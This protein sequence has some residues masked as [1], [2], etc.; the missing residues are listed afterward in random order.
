MVN[1][2]VLTHEQIQGIGQQ[3]SD[4]SKM[5]LERIDFLVAQNRHLEALPL[6]NVLD[7]MFPLAESVYFQ[8]IRPL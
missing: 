8:A 1:V 6:L 4:D 5:L 7:E 2:N 3:M